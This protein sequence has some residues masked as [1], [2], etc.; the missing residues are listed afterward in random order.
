MVRRIL[1]PFVE[2]RWGSQTAGVQEEEE[3]LPEG[4]HFWVHC[5]GEDGDMRDL[6]VNS[7]LEGMI[8]KGWM[9]PP[10][11]TTHQIIKHA[12]KMEFQKRK[13]LKKEPWGC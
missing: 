11:G 13:G 3:V 2:P 9:G 10:R 6:K 7:V 4:R 1:G 8:P 12:I 5:P